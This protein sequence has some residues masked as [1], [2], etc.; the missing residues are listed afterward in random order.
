MSEGS[1]TLGPAVRLRRQWLLAAACAAVGVVLG[2]DA[3]RE[4][5]MAIARR[6]VLPTTAVLGFEL[7]FLTRHLDRNRTAEGRL[8]ETL[9][10]ANAVT[11][12][13]GGLYA[14]VAGFV[15]VPPTPAVAWL[16]GVCYGVGAAL[17]WIDGRIATTI[18]RV[19]RLG[20]TLDH[21]FDTLG[22][23]VAP[24]VG[25]V[26]GR[27]PV[28]YLA[29]SFARY[30]FKAARAGRRHRGRPVYDLPESRV[31]RP[32]AAGQ[33]AFIT[34]ALLPVLPAPTVHVAATLALV[35]SL[36]VFARDYLVVSGRLRTDGSP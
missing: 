10:P 36:A 29:L 9:G 12:V 20:A 4:F 28:W 11:L 25:V 17:D 3:L 7:W 15:F 5:D 30:V 35:P 21:A 19:T 13:R 24:L 18:G 22:F 26:W 14:A 23:L 32:L 16:P 27:L 1:G 31:R 33:M 8:C 2:W 34:L 6:W